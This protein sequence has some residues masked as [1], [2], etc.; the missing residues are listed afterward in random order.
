MNNYKNYCS[1][2]KKRDTCTELCAPV[3]AL[4][5]EVTTRAEHD[6]ELPREFTKRFKNTQEWLE[7]RKT[8]KQLIIELYFID[9]RRQSDIVLIVGCSQPYVSKVIRQ[10]KK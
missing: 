2:C 5:S 6:R 3:E 8:K 7:S 1:K 4:L 9:G 10:A